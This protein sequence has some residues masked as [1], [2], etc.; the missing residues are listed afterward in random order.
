MK[1]TDHD[2]LVVAGHDYGFG[3]ARLGIDGDRRKEGRPSCSAYRRFDHHDH[4]AVTGDSGGNVEH[5]PYVFVDRFRSGLPERAG[6]LHY[7]RTD[8]TVVGNVDVSRLTVDYQKTRA[9][10]NVG[11]TVAFERFE[12]CPR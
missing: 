9:G 2:G 10:Q 8:G 4:K 11:K 5:H 7:P 12:R 1:S 6:A 3:A